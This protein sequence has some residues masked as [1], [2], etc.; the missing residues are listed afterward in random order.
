MLRDLF[1]DYPTVH[2]S[3]HTVRNK[4]QQQ[5][6]ITAIPCRFSSNI[7]YENLQNDTKYG[8]SNDY[9]LL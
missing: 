9:L 5:Q 2:A 3:T 6:P 1:S 7:R 8:Q 4:S